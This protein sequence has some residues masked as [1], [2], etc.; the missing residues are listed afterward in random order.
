MDEEDLSRNER[1]LESLV[2]TLN[3]A[4]I[5][6][7]VKDLLILKSSFLGDFMKTAADLASAPAASAGKFAEEGLSEAIHETMRT[8]SSETKI[9]MEQFNR[10]LDQALS[11]KNP[12]NRGSK[13]D[14]IKDDV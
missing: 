4:N 3:N 9:L 11:A 8:L 14:Q 10:A 2:R 6:Q 12:S 5:D 1:D 13:E 7:E